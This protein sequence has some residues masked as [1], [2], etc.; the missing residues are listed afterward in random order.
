MSNENENEKQCAHENVDSA[1]ETGPP[2]CGKYLTCHTVTN[3]YECLD[4]GA[5]L[6]TASYDWCCCGPWINKET[7]SE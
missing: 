3:G 6:I 5:K 7:A 1:Y 2:P 4:C